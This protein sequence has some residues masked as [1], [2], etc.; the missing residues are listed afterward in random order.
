[1]SQW[2]PAAPLYDNLDQRNIQVWGTTQQPRMLL[3]GCYQWQF[4]NAM[5]WTAQPPNAAPIAAVVPALPAP[6]LPAAAALTNMDLHRFMNIIATVPPA[7]NRILL[8][9]PITVPNGLRSDLLGDA[10]APVFNSIVNPIIA[11]A[12]AGQLPANIV[13]EDQQAVAPGQYLCFLQDVT[14]AQH[15]LVYGPTLKQNSVLTRQVTRA[16]TGTATG[17][18]TPATKLTRQKDFRPDTRARDMICR[19]TGVPV[20]LRARG[21]NFS[22]FEAA[23][24]WG[25]GMVKD[26]IYITSF[27]PGPV[28]AVLRQLVQSDA[29]KPRN[30]LLMLAHMHVFFDDYQLSFSRPAPNSLVPRGYKFERGGA[31][32][33]TPGLPMFAS[34]GDPAIAATAPEF[35]DFHFK[36]ALLWHVGGTGR[37]RPARIQP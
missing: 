11:N 26:V 22:A 31:T 14:N 19:V 27:E 17:A 1:M 36:T 20:P 16:N 9:G 24:V 23:H 28:Q 30:G 29:D 34:Q 5:P 21:A 12:L 4:P 6:N 32:G 3:G 33:F 18:L 37:P 8:V 10:S 25:H 35:L 15:I 2:N 13:P 7:G